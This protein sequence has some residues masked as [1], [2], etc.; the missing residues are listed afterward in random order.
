MGFR[1]VKFYGEVLVL[2]ATTAN[3]TMLGSTVYLFLVLVLDDKTA[4]VLLLP[5]VLL[6]VLLMTKMLFEF[7][8][9][10]RLDLVRLCILSMF[11]LIGIVICSCTRTTNH[12]LDDIYRSGVLW[13]PL[14]TPAR[15]LVCHRC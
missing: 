9:P 8:F 15:N 10:P 12:S 11:G 3:V 5:V 13:G 6:A 4:L 1:W 14:P 2:A 7:F